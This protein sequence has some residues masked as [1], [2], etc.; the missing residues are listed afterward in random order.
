MVK[1]RKFKTRKFRKIKKLKKTRN[2]KKLKRNNRSRKKQIKYGGSSGSYE[3][4]RQIS[5][6]IQDI[7]KSGTEEGLKHYIYSHLGDPDKKNNIYIR[8]AGPDYTVYNN[9][10]EILLGAIKE[11]RK[12]KGDKKG[13]EVMKFIPERIKVVNKLNNETTHLEIKTNIDFMANAVELNSDAMKYVS[14]DIKHNKEFM[15]K[16]VEKNGRALQ[17]ILASSQDKYPEI[18]EKAINQN[19]LALKYAAG[20]VL[21]KKKEIVEEAVKKNGHYLQYVP[22][23]VLRK[24]K[25]IVEEAV[26]KNGYYLQYVPDDMKRDGNIVN[27]AVNEGGDS[28]IE[29]LKTD[30]ESLKH[31]PLNERSGDL[32]FLKLNLINYLNMNGEIPNLKLTR[33]ISPIFKKIITRIFGVTVK[34]NDNKKVEVVEGEVVEFNPKTD[35]N[36]GITGVKKEKRML[37]MQI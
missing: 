21:S 22:D 27:N 14:E 25:E 37:F 33:D 36:L 29:S 9:I 23:D 4:T 28:L 3:V 32:S 12:Q 15:Q 1:I 34:K 10:H 17:H 20:I 8:P 2:L 31:S 19:G 11:I 30:I 35:D 13:E 7:K 5:A 6:L 26:K 18:V 16:A 24:N